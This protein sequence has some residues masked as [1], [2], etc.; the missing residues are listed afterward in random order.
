MTTMLD[1]EPSHLWRFVEF[2]FFILLWFGSDWL[3]P[4]FLNDSD[5]DTFDDAKTSFP[6]RS[7]YLSTLC[8]GLVREVSRIFSYIHKLAVPLA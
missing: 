3:I 8:E 1:Y 5:L 4:P 7:V 2:L 6:M